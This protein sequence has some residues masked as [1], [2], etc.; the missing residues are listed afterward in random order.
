MFY[1][2]NP[3]LLILT[4]YRLQIVGWAVPTAP[5]SQAFWWARPTLLFLLGFQ[6]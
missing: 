1:V 3:E 6:R 2:K 4:P 5:V